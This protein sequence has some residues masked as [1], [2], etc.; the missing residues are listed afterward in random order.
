MYKNFE[1]HMIYEDNF[2]GYF[3]Q[4]YVLEIMQLNYDLIQILIHYFVNFYFKE[5]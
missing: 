4:I 5:K 1:N 3:I 2:F